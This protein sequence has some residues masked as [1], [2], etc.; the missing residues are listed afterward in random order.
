MHIVVFVI[1]RVFIT[2]CSQITFL[3]HIEILFM[4]S[5][6]PHSDVELTSFEKKRPLDI[7]LNNPVWIVFFLGEEFLNLYQTIENLDT[8]SLVHVCWLDKPIIFLAMFL[9]CP[10][11]DAVSISLLKLHVSCS[12]LVKFE[13]VKFWRHNERSGSCIENAITRLNCKIKLKTS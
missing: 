5:E 10:L 9:W 7:F 3:I 12:K 2:T 1:Q 4:C 13:G 6:R 8:S 11:L